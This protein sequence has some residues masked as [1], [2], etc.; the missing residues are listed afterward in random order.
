MSDPA[1]AEDKLWV[2]GT[3]ATRP[4]LLH[5]MIRVRD[6][7]A[8]LGFYCDGMGMKLLDRYD[9]EAYKFSILFL[10]FDDYGAGP[11]IELTYNWGVEEP[12]SHG[13]GY[14][15]IA[16]GVPD[17]KQTAMTLAEHGGIISKEPYVLVP[18]GP[19][20][21]FVKDPD[22]YSIELIQTHRSEDSRG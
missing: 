17:V 11:A 19:M 9:F 20:M 8:S 6:I 15:H 7:D 3:D 5:S 2:W 14:G 18:G 21:A 12:Y 16:L 1:D 10:S 4:R 22:G 13:S